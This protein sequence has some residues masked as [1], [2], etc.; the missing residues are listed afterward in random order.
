MALRQA[1]GLSYRAV[2]VELVKWGRFG[3]GQ[4]IIPNAEPGHLHKDVRQDFLV[5]AEVK[6]ETNE[7]WVKEAVRIGAETTAGASIMAAIAASNVD[8][9]VILT[10]SRIQESRFEPDVPAVVLNLMRGGFMPAEDPTP[11]K[12]TIQLFHELGHVAQWITR[13][14]WFL[15][16]KAASDLAGEPYYVAIEKDNLER[17]ERPMCI[18]MGV[19]FRLCYDDIYNNEGKAQQ[20]WNNL[21]AAATTF[22]RYFRAH[23]A[24]Q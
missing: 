22:Q 23:Q 5:M 9:Y 17:Y 16:N 4:L 19:P 11:I 10:I 18:E 1:G 21:N 13:R 8:I 2:K 6:S 24:K 20:R 14:D 12:S 15:E 3:V 7:E